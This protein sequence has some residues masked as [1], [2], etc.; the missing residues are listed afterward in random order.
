M[1]ERIVWESVFIMINQSDY[2]ALAAGIRR[3]GDGH[4]MMHEDG[5]SA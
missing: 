2:D 5:Q 4:G 1:T 3:D